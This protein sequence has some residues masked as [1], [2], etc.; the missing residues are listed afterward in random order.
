MKRALVGLVGA[1]TLVGCP[2]RS[3]PKANG[4]GVAPSP[5]VINIVSSTRPAGPASVALSRAAVPDV[6]RFPALPEREIEGAVADAI[7]AKQI[8]GA[9][10]VI[11]RRDGV[12]LRRAFG[13]RQTTPTPEAMTVD[14][15]FDVASLTKVFVTAPSLALLE[16]RGA[17]AWSD[18]VGEHL[19]A[20]ATPTK[21]TITL[22]DLALHVGGLPRVNS[23]AEYAGTPAENLARALAVDPVA[24]ARTRFDYSDL[25]YIALG[26]VVRSVS[27]KPL[28]EFAAR[29]IFAPLGMGETGFDK[30]AVLRVRTAPTEIT[31]KRTGSPALIRGEAHDPRAFR[32]GGVA[33]HAGLF[34]TADDMAR[35]ARMMLRGGELDGVRVLKP[36]TVS[37]MTERHELLG[38]TRTLGWDVL[39]PYAKQKSATFSKAAYGHSGF[40]GVSLWIDPEL[41]LF[42]L[43]LTNRVHPDGKGDARPLARRIADIAVAAAPEIAPA[44]PVGAGTLLGIDVL[45]R[46]R[47]AAL[48]GRHVGLITNVSGRARDGVPTRE[49]LAQAPGVELVAL[50]APEHGLSGNREG[51]IDADVD[52]LT[53]VS[54]FSL[55]GETRTPTEESLR[56]VDTLVF[57]IQDA[58][59]RFYTYGATLRAAME[60]AAA[61]GLR[62][63]VLDR[64]NPLMDLGA[65]G[66][67]SDEGPR[68]FVNYFPL[69]ILHGLTLGELAKTLNAE[70]KL[71]LDLVVVPVEVYER[72]VPWEGTHL[73]WEP[74]SPNLPTLESVR[75]YPGTALVEA[76]NI[77]V[78]RGTDAPFTRIG[79][80]WIDGPSLCAALLVD[81]ATCTPER[82]TPGVGPFRGK[83][84]PGVRMRLVRDN[85]GRVSGDFDPVEWGFVLIAALARLHPKHFE[86][87]AVGKLLRSEEV[88]RRLAAA[89]SPKALARANRPA[90]N[91]FER[92]VHWLYPHNPGD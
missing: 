3:A 6:V 77:S 13:A 38:A 80:P 66:P 9:V 74:P 28:D 62:F 39:S 24:P 82:F 57:D 88:L 58:G 64:P 25:D 79:A 32:L 18:A 92:S 44:L 34:S 78:G 84:I 90:S 36:G 53:G 54:V 55:F 10:V 76:M 49:L 59:V 27:G 33:G 35:F 41:D 67:V 16:E 23:M 69:P 20:F 86:G 50:F 91:P 30:G 63:V 87:N 47:F 81:G 46:D 8:P 12:V 43:V 72:P 85:A 68:T 29:E 65:R 61:R 7:A 22:S 31:D 83:S 21:R 11:G 48:A 4:P 51:K 19:P 37:R 89:E 52:P 17:I 60:V 42:V 14:T 40:T 70:L 75:F 1:L 5:A 15:V 56:G 26:E 2:S 71:N 45:R 73:R